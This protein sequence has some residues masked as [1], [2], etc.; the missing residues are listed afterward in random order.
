MLNLVAPGKMPDGREITDILLHKFCSQRMFSA[1]IFVLLPLA[2]KGLQF[3]LEDTLV[4]TTVDFKMPSYTECLP[5][6]T[7]IYVAEQ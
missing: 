5:I 2:E 7:P 1:G 6:C 4:C 3:V